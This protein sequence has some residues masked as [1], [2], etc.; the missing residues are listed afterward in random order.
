ML[1]QI[2]QISV[3]LAPFAHVRTCTRLRGLVGKLIP[4]PCGWWTKSLFLE[5]QNLRI[6]ALAKVRFFRTVVCFDLAGTDTAR[7]SFQLSKNI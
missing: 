2:S 7:G 3:H 6:L 5:V 4:E 1:S